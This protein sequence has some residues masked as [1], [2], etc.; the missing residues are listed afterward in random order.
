MSFA[1][2]ASALLLSTSFA[3]AC[4]PADLDGASVGKSL[5]GTGYSSFNSRQ[6]FGGA[7]VGQ[8]V[9]GLYF[10][11]TPRGDGATSP[12]G[13]WMRTS[14]NDKY[15]P[16]LGMSY[17][18][19]S[20]SSV[21]APAGVFQV[22]TEDGEESV[23]AKD[24]NLLFEIGAPLNAQ[25]RISKTLASGAYTRYLAEVS[26][27]G[28][29]WTNYCPH[30]YNDASGV[31]TSLTEYLI[32]VGGAKWGND[33]ARVNDSNAIQ[34]SC[35]HDSIGGCVTWGYAPWGTAT[36]MAGTPPKLTTVS[37]QNAHQAC[38]RA[39]RADVCGDGDHL[40]TVNAG[41][42]EHTIVQVWDA[43]N[44][45]PM[46][47]HTFST[48]EASWGVGGAVCINPEEFRSNDPNYYDHLM[49]QLRRPGCEKSLCTSTNATG[50]ISTGRPCLDLDDEGHCITH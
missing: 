18:G 33:G 8:T 32:P 16:V 20:I 35:T 7:M 4:G 29:E 41:A 50:L 34:L 24:V 2:Y 19:N 45:H 6:A 10:S 42:F 37:L 36:T 38:T 44:L 46:A 31:A 28:E 14:T 17:N 9:T 21:S 25:L 43:Y 49:A 22:E 12:T 26:T 5:F 40:T 30:P 11:T 3:T 39:K 48:M 15:A 13:Y 1:K 47:E 23:E 27:N